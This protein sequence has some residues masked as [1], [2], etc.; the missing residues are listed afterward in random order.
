MTIITKE[1][2][3]TASLQTRS[4]GNALTHFIV[5]EDV[6][7]A[8]RF[9]SDVLGGEIVLAGEPTIVA[10]ANSW[11]I[12]NVGGGPT[13]HRFDPAAALVAWRHDF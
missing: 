12:I 7:P 5:A 11:I 2:T 1:N 4:D 3:A 8:A 10:L 6:E 9:Y 13:D